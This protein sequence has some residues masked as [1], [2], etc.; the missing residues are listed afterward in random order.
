MRK[1]LLVASIALAAVLGSGLMHAANALTLSPPTAELSA[2]PGETAAV[3]ARLYNEGAEALVIQPTVL[4]FNSK[5]ETGQP[6]FYD[7]KTGLDLQHWISV[8]DSLML[9]PGETRSVVVT[10]AVP[11]DADPGGHYAAIFWG[12]SPPKVEGSGA[13]VEGQIAM[14]FLVNVEGKIKEDAEVIEFHPLSS[15]LTHLPVD[16]MVRFQNNGSVHEHPAGDIIIR[17]MFG[18]QSAVLPFNIQPSIGNVLPKSIRRFDL[19][20]V[21]RAMD[22]S[23]S[24]WSQEWQNFALGYYTAE[25]NITY[26]AGNTLVT[27]RTSFWVIPWMVSLVGLATLIIIVLILRVLV[28]NYNKSVIRKYTQSNQKK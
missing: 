17:N 25:L 5:D 11:K 15:F 2:K 3:V 14:L 16:L 20:W 9:A 26:G 1:T 22:G 23:A 28:I 7:D 4:S 12:T 27:A 8:P 18:R 6:N 10:V 13:G 24:E 19:S 21:K